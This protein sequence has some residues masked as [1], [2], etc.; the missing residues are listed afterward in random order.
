MEI[1]ML[2]GFET[3]ISEFE[4]AANGSA[5][6]GFG[7]GGSSNVVEALGGIIESVAET[8]SGVSTSIIDAF[9]AA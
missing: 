9:A 5:V 6:E 2:N 8:F 4:F 7:L 1:P 3:T